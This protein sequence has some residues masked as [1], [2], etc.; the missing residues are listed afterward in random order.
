[1]LILFYNCICG[2]LEYVALRTLDLVKLTNSY[3]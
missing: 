3:A 2:D 1:M